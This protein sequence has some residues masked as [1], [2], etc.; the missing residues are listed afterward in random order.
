LAGDKNDTQAALKVSETLSKGMLCVS[1]KY[2][3]DK[4]RTAAT[5]L[6]ITIA[7]TDQRLLAY[8]Q[9]NELL[10]GRIFESAE[11]LNPCD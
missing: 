9:Y 1:Q 4:V 5:L 2:E 11:D 8:W 6:E 10:S 3:G 7:N